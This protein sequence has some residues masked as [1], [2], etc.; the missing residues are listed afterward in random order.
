[1]QFIEA[2]TNFYLGSRLDPETGEEMPGEVVY[3]DSRDLTT[4]AVVLGMTGSG[5]TGLCIDILEE[6]V[7]DGI[8]SIIIDPKGDITNLLLAF[9]AFT[10]DYFGPWVNPD[11]VQR[12]DLSH[13][14]FAAAA[15]TRWKEGLAEW[16]INEARVQAFRR[17]ARYSIYTPGSD[18]GLPVSIMHSLTV[19]RQ[20][21]QGNEEMLRERIAGTV[22]AL[23]ALIGMEANPVEDREH[24]LLS[25][26]F[27]YNWKN[28]QSLTLESLIL[29]VQRPP[30]AKLGVFDV[31]TLFPEKDRF[32]LAMSLNNIIASPRFQAWIQGEPLDVSSLLFT[33]EGAPRV[34]IF[35]I[36]HLTDA[37]RM[38]IV[39]LLLESILSWMRSLSGVTSLR[40]LLY[41]D[42]VFGM[43]PPHPYNPPTKDPILRL[44]KQGRAFGLGTIVATQ[45]PKDLDYKGLSNAGTWFI[46]K[47]QTD[48]DKERVLEGLDSARDAQSRLDLRTV[49][50]LIGRLGPREFIMHNI[51]NPESPILMKT[52]W[53]MSYL[54]G[55][56]T[57]QQ[58]AE[59]MANQKQAWQPAGVIQPA[60]QPPTPPTSSGKSRA[61]DWIAGPSAPS[62]QA[63]PAIGSGPPPTAQERPPIPAPSATP[64][65]I[66]DGPPGFSPISPPLPS[67]IAQYYV[68]TELT[69]EQ[70]VRTWEESTNQA[71]MTVET[72]RRLLY[73]PG[74][75]A[76][77][78]VHFSD[79]KTNTAETRTQAFLVT[80]VS[81]I[82][83]LNWGEYQVSPFDMN[84]L[85]HQPFT[86]ALYADTPSSLIDPN[87]LKTLRADLEEW[88]FQNSRL[89]VFYNPTLK[90]YGQ[91]GGSKRDFLAQVQAV[92]REKRDEEVDV[93]A[94]KY[95]KRLDALE[96]RAQ[97][98]AMRLESER[99]ELDAR[100]REELLTAGETIMQL[101]RG[102][103]Y[104]TLS[105]TSRM[106]RYTSMSTDQVGIYEAQ[107]TDI[108][109][110][111]EATERE[112]EAALQEVQQKWSAIAAQIE[113]VEVNPYKKDIRVTLFG[114]GWV[115]HW[116]VV[117]NSKE[118]I[119]P[120]TLQGR[121]Q[122]AEGGE[123]PT[124]G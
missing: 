28:G 82:G 20:G 34:S 98:K 86:D 113:E 114:L 107:L 45:N 74:L 52:R 80:S 41:I 22:T 57:R 40:A 99:T 109:D 73:R 115:P 111:L 84:S 76:Q 95:D 6:A 60:V 104:R 120:A 23:L 17:A 37:E 1:M 55:P 124:T 3:Y 75:L 7:I 77:V 116:D 92:A 11:D 25:N 19:P 59:L 30:F 32:A 123:S 122:S 48:I 105:R 58:V 97:Q 12:S 9:P 42:E 94:Q 46:G 44:L 39:T 35:Y 89:R 64:T 16:G 96:Q 13:Q 88:V 21:W 110:Q 103:S 15:A 43:F 5:K 53:T 93:V 36:A 10:A 102:H 81:R 69:P 50:K 31:E 121:R 63:A 56:L 24:I 100:K 66:D 91:I 72:R 79:R 2:P 71:A 101:F 78:S 106:R 117:V 54:R 70:A 87:A 85:E 51:H 112:M 90:L 18:A 47:M 4:H 67:T 83:H 68:P 33:P 8:P 108:A 14:E 118:L 38:F 26:I 61:M 49:D 65:P 29:Q 119:L 62:A 27:E